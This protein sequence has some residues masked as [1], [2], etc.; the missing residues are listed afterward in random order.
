M[1]LGGGLR[2][3]SV[4]LVIIVTLPPWER[5]LNWVP[6]PTPPPTRHH[7]DLTSPAPSENQENTPPQDASRK[8]PRRLRP[9][10]RKGNQPGLLANENSASRTAGSATQ[11]GS[12]AN[13][14]S[15]FSGSSAATR[16]RSMASENSPL[17]GNRPGTRGSNRSTP[18]EHPRT[19]LRPQ[20]PRLSTNYNSE[21]RFDLD[22]PKFLGVYKLAQPSI[23]QDSANRLRR[24]PFSG[25]GLSSPA[26]QRSHRDSFSESPSGQLNKEI[27][28]TD[29]NRE[30]RIVG[31][32]RP[33]IVYPLPRA[34]RPDTRLEVDAAPPEAAALSHAERPPTV[35]DIPETGRL[36]D[37]RCPES[38]QKRG[39]HSPRRHTRKRPRNRSS[40]VYRPKKRSPHRGHWCE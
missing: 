40:G 15:A 27:S 29:S 14:N 1:L 12:P 32:S 6:D 38:S 22:H 25:S 20:H 18:V 26:L 2:S 11:L 28:L 30:A 31:G 3:P 4:F 33:G 19:F 7:G 24:D 35:L 21:R 23:Q 8:L 17:P 36:Q 9:R 37:T 13:R 5:Y 16:P 34:A 39:S 10:R